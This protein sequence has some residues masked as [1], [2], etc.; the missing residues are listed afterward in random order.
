MTAIHAI[1]DGSVFIPEKPCKISKGAKVALTVSIIGADLSEK[2]KKLAD[3]RKLTKEVNELNKT[4]PL[5]AEF[6]EILS[7]RMRIR[8][9]PG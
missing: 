6:D 9:V 1:Y 7:Q 3:F 4:D 8:E 2:Q 5:P